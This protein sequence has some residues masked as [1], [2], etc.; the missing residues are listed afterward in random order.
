MPNLFLKPPSNM[1]TKLSISK[2]L[3]AQ[4]SKMILADLA[5]LADLLRDIPY[6]AFITNTVKTTLAERYFER[7]VNRA[8][9]INF[10]LLR[11]A[12]LPPPDDYTK[13]FQQLATAH[14]VDPDLAQRIAPAAG[15]RNILVHEYDDLDSIQF[16][17]SLQNALEIFPKYLRKIANYVDKNS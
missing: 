17:S 5:D 13:S 11:A 6:E 2:R 14:I 4:K 15:A 3:V 1:S 16:Y 7:M 9:D 8:I 12:G 10:H